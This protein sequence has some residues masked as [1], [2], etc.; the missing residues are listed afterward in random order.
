MPPDAPSPFVYDDTA[1]TRAGIVMLTQTFVGQRIG[2]VGVGGT[3]S[4]VLDLVS[5]TPVA[6][7]HA[8]DE[9]IFLQ[10]NAFRSPGAAP[11]ADVEA[12]EN[13]AARLERLYREM[14]TGVIAHPYAVTADNVHELTVLDFVFLCMDAGSAKESLLRALVDVEVPFVDVGLGVDE[15]DGKLSGQLRVTTS[16]PGHAGHLADRIALAEDDADA[17]YGR[18]IQIAELNALNAALAVIR[19]KKHL[20]FYADLEHEHHSIYVISGNEIINEDR[21]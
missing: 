18:N 14:H 1:S 17:D 3:G 7:I 11:L 10:H 12:Q 2:I 5:K 16:T 15:I 9:D 6:Q 20:G 13:K 8:F 4:Y 19:W 21:S